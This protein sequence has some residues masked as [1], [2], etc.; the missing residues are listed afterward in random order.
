[1][2]S[3]DKMDRTAWQNSEVM[4]EFEKKIV[5]SAQALADNLTKKAQSFKD[6]PSDLA[7][8]NQ[9]AGPAAQSMKEVADATQKLYSGN[10]DDKEGNES[11]EKDLEEIAEKAEEVVEE[12]ADLIEELTKLSY[13]VADQG[14]TELAYK[15]ERVIRDIEAGRNED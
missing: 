11:A 6:L 7:K 8:V 1:M 9:E 5:E 3:W 13:F 12:L 14:D 4:Q 2:S 10:A 15:L